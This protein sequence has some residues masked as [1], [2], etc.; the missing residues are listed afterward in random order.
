MSYF[1]VNFLKRLKV[2]YLSYFENTNT[3]IFLKFYLFPVA[4]ITL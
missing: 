2:N 1:T 4:L 3:F